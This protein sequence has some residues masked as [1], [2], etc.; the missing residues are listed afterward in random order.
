[1]YPTNIAPFQNVELFYRIYTRDPRNPKRI[2]QDSGRRVCHS[3]VKGALQVLWNTTFMLGHGDPVSM[4]NMAGGS[5]TSP[6]FVGIKATAPVNDDD[7]GPIVGTGT[8]AESISDTA[9]ATRILHGTGAGQLQH[10][11]VTFGAP[12][13]SGATVTMRVTRTF[14]NATASTITIQELGLA[15]GY[16]VSG[17]FNQGAFLLIRDLY[18]G[19]GYAV[20]AGLPATVNYDISTT[21]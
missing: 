1:M 18:G 6:D 10:G 14:T 5:Q 9:L 20:G 7:F 17:V 4:T 11:G 15:T 13:V 16:Y 2:L 19:G 8:A 21:A 12:S 3:W